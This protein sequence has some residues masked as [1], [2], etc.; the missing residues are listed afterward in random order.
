MPWDQIVGWATLAGV[1]A[2]IWWGKR[3]SRAKANNIRS[4]AYS[5]AM[6]DLAIVQTVNV[7]GDDRRSVV[8]D[9]S[10]YY[11]AADDRP[12]HIDAA[13][14]RILLHGDG[15]G[16]LDAGGTGPALRAGDGRNGQARAVGAP[17]DR[18]VDGR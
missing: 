12:A 13:M 16:Q 2:A 4:E 14:R 1:V 3:A 18:D 8:A 7:H 15:R 11:D 6:R 9:G 5:Q 10:A 17:V